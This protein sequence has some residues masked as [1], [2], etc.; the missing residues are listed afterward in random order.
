MLLALFVRLEDAP[1]A[2][3]H[4]TDVVRVTSGIGL[5]P[6]P[7]TPREADFKDTLSAQSKRGAHAD[8]GLQA[9]KAEVA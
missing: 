9:L 3:S 4:A 8:A 5:H 2:S 6:F 7:A 1:E